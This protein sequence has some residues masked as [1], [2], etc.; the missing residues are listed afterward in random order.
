MGPLCE[1]IHVPSVST[2]Y[3]GLSHHREF[4]QRWDEHIS[5][6]NTYELDHL[7]VIQFRNLWNE[8][9]TLVQQQQVQTNIWLYTDRANISWPVTIGFVWPSVLEYMSSSLSR[10][11]IILDFHVTLIN[12]TKTQNVIISNP[13]S[14]L[15]TYSVELLNSY[16]NNSKSIIN[17]QIFTISTTSQE[18]KLINGI[19]NFNLSSNDQILFTVFYQ[20]TSSIKHEMYLVVRNNLTII[21]S[22]HLR[23]EGGIGSLQVGNR[24]AGSSIIPIVLKIDEKQY[25]L[26]SI[27][28]NENSLL[29]KV[30]TLRNTG[31][32]KTIIHDISFSHSKCSGQGFSVSICT[33]IEIEPHEKYDLKILFQ[34]DY[35][36][37]EINETLILNTNTG[38]MTFPI[39]VQIPQRVLLSCYKTI[40]RPPWELRTYGLCF[41]SFFLFIILIF[42]T[43]V[44]EARRLFDNYLTRAEWRDRMQMTNNKI[45]DLSDLSLAV[46]DEQKARERLES[47]ST[48][49]TKKEKTIETSKTE[50]KR[51]RSMTSNNDNEDKLLKSTQ[52]SDG[53]NTTF[54]PVGVSPKAMSP[55]QRRATT[56]S[57][58]SKFS[59]PQQEILPKKQSLQ[60]RK[61][62]QH[63]SVTPRKTVSST[64]MSEEENE[65]FVVAR[66]RRVS[67]KAKESSTNIAS[68]STVDTTIATKQKPSVHSHQ[69]D[70]LQLDDS[71]NDQQWHRVSS[72][73]GQRKGPTT[74]RET[75]DETQ[76]T[77]KIIKVTSTNSENPRT[78]SLSSPSS[79]KHSSISHETTPLHHHPSRD[80]SALN[81]SP[82]P[83]P[84]LTEKKGLQGD[85]SLIPTIRELSLRQLAEQLWAAKLPSSATACSMSIRSRCSSAPASE[86]G[87]AQNE[88]TKS[89]RNDN[90]KEENIDWDEPDIPDEDFG[91]YAS[92]T[93][94]SMDELND[95]NEQP[96][97][98]LTNNIP[99]LM[100]LSITPPIIKKTIQEKPPVST[101]VVKENIEPLP[102]PQHGLGPI[103]RPNKLPCPATAQSSSF[104]TDSTQ[105]P[106]TPDVLV[107]IN[108]LLDHSNSVTTTA[109]TPNVPISTNS[110]T[111]IN[112]ISTPNVSWTP[113]SPSEWSSKYDSSWSTTNLQSSN[114]SLTKPI[115]NPFLQQQQQQ[116]SSEESS[117]WSSAL[118]TTTANSASSNARTQRTSEWHELFSSNVP[119]STQ[120][121]KPT[122]NSW[123]KFLP[124]SDPSPVDSIT[125]NRQEN[126]TN[127]AF[128]NLIN[129]NETQ[130]NSSAS[131]WPKTSSDGNNNDN[132]QSRWD[133]AR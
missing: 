51:K 48:T 37:D 18:I 15:V 68:Q 41:C 124:V 100:S 10:I 36:S 58:P 108:R 111:I 55:K 93:E 102:F 98:Y 126:E 114:I 131:W 127:N 63:T 14:D 83:V 35:T 92:Q 112:E 94:C 4:K 106:S 66:S 67:N 46:Q 23:G 2:C 54:R 129:P 89:N 12:I 27:D 13:S 101:S 117:V 62:D 128:W 20:P 53:S 60:R 30:V 81:P 72:N 3:C 22:I 40:P 80:R 121:Q 57:G 116:I 122:N 45:F 64:T 52:T 90:G 120:I 103:Q 44:Y 85:T 26:C 33:D 77:N 82:T 29:R 17:D 25:G 49:D 28:K 71:V 59:K 61:S 91:R 1:S 75:T 56:D 39:I 76:T 123:L 65:P 42:A 73:K 24:Q 133:F 69:Q 9:T 118:G 97:Q 32:M 19:Y 119:S 104:R 74:R 34:P 109:S 84:I 96:Q 6:L 125:S 70:L 31:N 115:Q 47:N 99:S 132:D 78:L 105:S 8:W 5:A 43:A 21:E 110:S 86:H 130:Q 38:L 95:I 50:S 107:Q 16:P 88:K 7:L 87:G 11:P 113:F 79:H